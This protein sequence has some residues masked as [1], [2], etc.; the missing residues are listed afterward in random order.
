MISSCEIFSERAEITALRELYSSEYSS[1]RLSSPVRSEVSS[2]SFFSDSSIVPASS[3]MRFFIS[4]SSLSLLHI[5]L[6]LKIQVFL[7]RLV[8]HV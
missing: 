4:F 6:E 2:V 5:L 7:F 3:E 8:P 1:L